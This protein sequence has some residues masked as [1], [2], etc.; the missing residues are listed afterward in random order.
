[1]KKLLLV[2]LFALPTAAQVNQS[3]IC[4]ALLAGG[5]HDRYN[6]F[7]SQRLFNEF[8]R[9]LSSETFAS[10][11]SAQYSQ[12]DL[13][14][15]VLDILS[16]AFGGTTDSSNYAT[17]R[18]MLLASDFS[19]F[20]SDSNFMSHMEVANAQL[21]GAFVLCVEKTSNIKG[22]TAWVTPSKTLESFVITAR[23]VTDGSPSFTIQQINVAPS[24]GVSCSTSLPHA[25]QQTTYTVT[26]T[27]PAHASVQV[28]M[29]TSAGILAPT[30]LDG[31]DDVLAAI[32]AD[33][34]AIRGSGGLAPRGTV[35]YFE[36][37]SCPP[38][39]RLFERGRGR[40]LVG[41]QQGG[42]LGAEVGTALNDKENRATGKHLH[43]YLLRG[44]G[45]GGGPPGATTQGGGPG[46]TTTPNAQTQTTGEV[47]GTNA[48]YVQLCVCQKQ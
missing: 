27:K 20:S 3:E 7:S 24:S 17:R 12:T 11:E 35:A 22:F 48:P 1:M 4:R 40:Y 31:L 5:V 41:L 25:V 43:T 26:C 46:E 39:W 21:A 30:D 6:T 44:W 32:R 2:L 13:G 29:N 9:I 14:I 38:G 19:R 15:S 23:N 33:I 34:A 37:P 8:K 28:S 47:D 18:T 42:S 45:W 36:L 10:F 16:A